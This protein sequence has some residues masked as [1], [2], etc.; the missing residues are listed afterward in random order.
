LLTRLR[1]S[2]ERIQHPAVIDF[3]VWPGLRDR[4]VFEHQKYTSTGK[5]SAAFVENF[6]FHW[7][8]SERDIFA[9]NPVSNRYEVSKIFLAFAYDLK[10][11]TMRPDFFRKFPEMQSD[12]GMTEEIMEIP[13]PS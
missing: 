13:I 5:F 10:N 12:I 1:P 6:H 3:L 7:P 4:L 9:Y 11:W 2:Q 8:Y